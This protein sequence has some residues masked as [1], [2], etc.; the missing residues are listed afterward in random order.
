MHPEKCKD[1]GF[2]KCVYPGLRSKN[3]TIRIRKYPQICFKRNFV[4]LIFKHALH[5]HDLLLTF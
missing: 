1:L 2:T 5:I 3:T 4:I